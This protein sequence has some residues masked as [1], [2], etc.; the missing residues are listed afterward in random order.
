MDDSTFFDNI[1]AS[2]D[3]NETLSTPEKVNSILDL[4]NMQ[5]SQEI[6]DLG[7][8]TGVLL[9]FIAQR[10]G[11]KGKITAV[12]YSSGMLDIAR[13]KFST[14][15]PSP[16]FLKLDF[17][18]ENIPGEFDRIILYCVYPHLHTPIETL[19]WITKVNL[20]K[21]GILVI[22]FPCGPDFINNIHKERKSESDKL[23]PASQLAEFLCNNGLKAEVKAESE[24][25]YVIFLYP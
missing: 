18:N 12:D 5:P 10:I 20:K 1:A 24:D 6:L 11:E 7:T 4:L 15:S 13:K 19:K 9:P 3:A 22:A 16:V 8:G 14:L 2:W 21:T 25:K 17:E 23:P